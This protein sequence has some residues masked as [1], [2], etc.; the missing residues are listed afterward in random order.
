[1]HF[2]LLFQMSHNVFTAELNKINREASNICRLSALEIGIPYEV[3]EFRRKTTRFGPAVVATLSRPGRDSIRVFL[4]S[5]FNEPLTDEELNEYNDQQHWS[6]SLI[7]RG[8]VGG[9]HDV[10]FV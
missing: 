5:R 4:P 3:L 8:I 10:Q 6:V 1:M 2:L 7:Y 9:R